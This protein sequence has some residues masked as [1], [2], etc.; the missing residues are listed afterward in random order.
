[1]KRIALLFLLCVTAV[2]AYSQKWEFYAGYGIAPFSDYDN[3]YSWSK[4]VDLMKFRNEELPYY[5]PKFEEVLKMSNSNALTL[6]FGIRVSPRVMIG[7]TYSYFDGECSSKYDEESVKCRLYYARNKSHVMLATCSYTWLNYKRFRF[8]S[9]LGVGVRTDS[10]WRIH[11]YEEP[12]TLKPWYPETPTDDSYRKCIKEN[13]RIDY[14]GYQLDPIGV[15]FH[16]FWKMYL[17]GE[18]GFGMQGY[19]TVGLKARF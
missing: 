12:Y 3:P 4:L 16:L 8:Y 18:A 13:T 7:F 9:K 10:R 2:S 17:Y 5:N 11:I 1:M 6:G 15:D 14:F 19:A